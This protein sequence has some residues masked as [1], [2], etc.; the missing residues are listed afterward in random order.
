G[1]FG[2]IIRKNKERMMPL[3]LKQP[4]QSVALVAK[5][6]SQETVQNAVTVYVMIVEIYIKAFVRTVMIMR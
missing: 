3:C 5:S 4:A 1:N 2:N 6:L